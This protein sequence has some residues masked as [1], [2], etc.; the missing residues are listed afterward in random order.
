[1]SR[2]GRCLVVLSCLAVFSLNVDRATANILVNSGFESQIEFGDPTAANWFAFFGAGSAGTTSTSDPGYTGIVDPTEGAN[3]LSITND[4]TA[5]GFSGV[6]QRVTGVAGT[7]YTFSFDARSNGA[8]SFPIGAEFRIEYL[9]ATGAVVGASANTPI[10]TTLTDQYQ[11]F[12]I[13]DTAQ[14]NN[15]QV[16]IAVETFS[17]SGGFGDLFVDNAVVE[18]KAIPE[19]ASAAL[20]C[21]GGLF[22]ATRRRR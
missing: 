21:L 15:L 8:A 4:G 10:G 12:S 6:F 1:M 19:P 11:S 2:L 7:D 17:A 14:T 22:A 18:A 20:L 9:D 16:V 3:H 13:V 5:S